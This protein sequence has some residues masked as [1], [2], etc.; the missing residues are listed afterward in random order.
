M[1]S[2][3][4]AMPAA[5]APERAPPLLSRD[6][7]FAMSGL[8]AL[9][10]LLE[11]RAA[12]PSIGVTLGFELVGIGDGFAVFEGRGSERVLNPM[13]AV[14]GGWALTLLDSCLGCAAHTKLAAGFS[15]T[16]IETKANFIR[17]ITP[18]TGLVRAEGRVIAAGRTIIMAQGDITDDKGRILAH[19]TSTLLVMAPKGDT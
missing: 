9:A 2:A 13:G 5:I 3:E 11:G 10:R 16:S 7:L 6:E 15:Y 17:P 1:Q 12:P 4:F 8:D 18:E 14:H 19:G